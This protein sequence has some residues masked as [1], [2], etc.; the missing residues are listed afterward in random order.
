MC[1]VLTTLRR[2]LF[3]LYCLPRATRPP[4]YG[5]GLGFHANITPL[6][7]GR[8]SDLAQ[9]D[10]EGDEAMRTWTAP[11]VIEISVGMEINCYACATL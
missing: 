2:L 6:I 8:A 3:H 7:G 4:T 1:R 11:R 10:D 9:V 5:L